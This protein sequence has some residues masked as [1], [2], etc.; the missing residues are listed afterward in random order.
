MG[1]PV[2][3]GLCFCSASTFHCSCLLLL[4]A[5]PAPSAAVE[6][7]LGAP[8]LFH[9]CRNARSQAIEARRVAFKVNDRCSLDYDWLGQGDAVC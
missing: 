3:R 4:V 9:P 6:F 5:P 7:V 1:K 8:P 2:D